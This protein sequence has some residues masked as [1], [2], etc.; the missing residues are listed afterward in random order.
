[1]K[2]IVQSA[3]LGLTLVLAAASAQAFQLEHHDGVL[4]LDTAP[5]RLV[6]YDL[7][8]LDTLDTLGIPVVGVPRSAYQGSLTQYNDAPL[9]GTLFEPDQDALR[10]L[11]PDLI[12]AGRRSLPAIPALKDLA[13][14]VHYVDPDRPFLEALRSDT[15]A[16][17]RAFG[18]EDQADEALLA[19]ERNVHTLHEGNRGKTAAFLFV[20]QDNV[21]AHA[22]GDRFGY[23]Y[24]LTGLESVLPAN[25]HGSA[26]AAPRPQPG[27]PE[28]K[29]AQAERARII[30]AVAQ[31]DPDWLIVLDRGAINNGEKTAARTL[32]AH[33]EL[34]QTRAFRNGH[35]YYA[36]PNGW[37]VVTGG[38]SNLQQ[39]TDDLLA[40]MKPDQ[41]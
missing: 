40:T 17:A 6:S 18:K 37:Y 3:A 12:F 36:D 19:I 7:G 27:S 21:I 13:P 2:R 8:V 31:A 38:L 34:S 4:E 23:A 16:L 32:S 35:V 22:P 14:T 39:I 41:P 10:R 28:H 33:P 1:M 24:E 30:H 9:V 5:G 15:M 25:E 29:A 26:P 11:E 20:I